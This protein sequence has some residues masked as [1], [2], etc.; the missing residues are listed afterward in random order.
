MVKVSSFI[1]KKSVIRSDG[2][3]KIKN[4]NNYQNPKNQKTKQNKNSKTKPNQIAVES[5]WSG[6][7]NKEN[8]T[9]VWF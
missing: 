8:E 7:K 6:T 2:K 9:A 4:K 5:Y 1:E 3:A